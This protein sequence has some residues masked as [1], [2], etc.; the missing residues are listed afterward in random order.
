VAFWVNYETTGLLTP[1][2][3]MAHV[4]HDGDDD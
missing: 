3:D 4:E 1:G 2:A